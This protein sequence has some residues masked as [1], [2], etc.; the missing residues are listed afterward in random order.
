MSIE[1][2]YKKRLR[3]ESA[4][5]KVE[6]VL[7]YLN[8]PQPVLDFIRRNVT[9]LK[10]T[11]ILFTVAVVSFSLWKSWH[12]R[13]IQ[14]AASALAV[15]AAESPEKRGDALKKVVEEYGST[16][17]ALWAKVKLAHLAR[18]EGRFQEAAQQYAAL[19]SD[20]AEDNPLFPLL[21][22][23]EARALEA[24]GSFEPAAKQYRKL[25]NIKG[26]QFLGSIGEGE[27]LEQQGQGETALA[28]YNNFIVTAGDNPALKQKKRMMEGKILQLKAVLSKK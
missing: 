4:Y 16:S 17:S 20:V 6:A 5:D 13:Q 21:V 7:E 15:A 24:A 22:Y 14:N 25:Q 3:P 28:I 11:L 23:G 12:E 1:S 18:N 9:I 2:A 8:L 26:F 27:I 10:W 19:R